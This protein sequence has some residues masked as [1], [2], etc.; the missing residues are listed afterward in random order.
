MPAWR[1]VGEHDLLLVDL[2]VPRQVGLAVP[3]RRL[4]L[5][6]EAV[7]LRAGA[8]LVVPGEDGVGVDLHRVDD[9]VD[10]GV[11]DGEDGLEVV[12]VARDR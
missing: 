5:L 2:G 7:E 3:H 9:G 10:V 8:L 4:G 11:G 6:V 1:G 12:D